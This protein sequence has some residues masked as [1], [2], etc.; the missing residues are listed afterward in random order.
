MLMAVYLVSSFYLIQS[1]KIFN[2]SQFHPTKNY[3]KK[4]IV[5]TDY[6]IIKLKI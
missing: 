6:K 3:Y 1:V 4:I 5:S 2:F